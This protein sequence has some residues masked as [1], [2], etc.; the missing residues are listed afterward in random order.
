MGIRE[1]F[2]VDKGRR[3]RER[4][5]FV[6]LGASRTY[7]KLKS[8]HP[9]D[10]AAITRP[11]SLGGGREVGKCPVV[12]SRHLWTTMVTTTTTEIMM[13]RASARARDG[14]ERVTKAG[15]E[16]T[17]RVE[18]GEGPDRGSTAERLLI[19]T[20]R[21]DQHKGIN[22]ARGPRYGVTTDDPSVRPQARTGP[23]TTTLTAAESRTTTLW[24]AQLL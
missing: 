14:G 7:N 17:G 6:F 3:G 24:S 18:N 1:P 15:G 9:R 5:I 20:N 4:R 16:R 13:E 23:L 8:H 19:Q 21:P 10:L 12:V 11:S 2:S 22:Y